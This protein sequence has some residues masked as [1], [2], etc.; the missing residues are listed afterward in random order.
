MN[1][2]EVSYQTVE[3]N[4]MYTVNHGIVGT[5]NKMCKNEYLKQVTHTTSHI[6]PRNIWGHY[7][8][9]SAGEKEHHH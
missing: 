7:I 3:V 2:R 5:P 8:F 9:I 6:L 1:A 4:Y